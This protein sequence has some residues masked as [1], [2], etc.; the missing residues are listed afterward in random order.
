MVGASSSLSL[1]ISIIVAKF[2]GSAL[3][4]LATKCNIDP[5]VMSAPILATLLDVIT[6]TTLFGIGIF[7]VHSLFTGIM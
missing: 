1:L 3:P 6:T 5:T 4:I 7:V 2:L